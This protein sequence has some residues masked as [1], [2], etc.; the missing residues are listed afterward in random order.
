[1]TAKGQEEEEKMVRLPARATIPFCTCYTRMNIAPR[2]VMITFF[3]GIMSV[4][5]L[6][7]TAR[8]LIVKD[9]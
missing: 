7:W 1:M 4:C 9:P 6:F 8:A 2:G 3:N 5:L